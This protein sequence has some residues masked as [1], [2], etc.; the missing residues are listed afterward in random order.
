MGGGG[1]GEYQDFPSKKFSLPVP[2]FS[3]GNPFVQCFRNFPVAEKFMDKREGEGVSRF[4][5]EKI[6]SHSAEKLRSGILYCS[7]NFRYRKIL[8]IKESGGASRFSAKIFLS[9]SAKFFVGQPFCAVF[10]KLS[11]REK[12]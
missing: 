1:G 9:H 8:G 2:N 11:G 7:T 10:Q 12:V 5:V 4:S 6:F 3:W